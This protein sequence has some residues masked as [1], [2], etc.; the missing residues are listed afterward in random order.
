M[1]DKST[2]VFVVFNRQFR[3][4]DP[5][6]RAFTQKEIYITP[7][8]ELQINVLGEKINPSILNIPT[9]RIDSILTLNNVII[10]LDKAVIWL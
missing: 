8:L 9:A 5:F 3:Q 7:D 2:S 1:R 4:R 10:T 6:F